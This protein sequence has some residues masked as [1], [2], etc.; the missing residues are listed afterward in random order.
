MLNGP[1]SLVR[2]FCNTLRARLFITK[3][4]LGAI[5]FISTFASV[6]DHSAEQTLLI[7]RLSLTWDYP[8]AQ[9]PTNAVE[10][11]DTVLMG[12][13]PTLLKPIVKPGAP[14]PRLN[15]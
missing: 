13:G 12:R 3:R 5:A 15:G 10:T 4:S 14:R 2:N 8:P 1:D 6:H 9:G 11:L 7:K